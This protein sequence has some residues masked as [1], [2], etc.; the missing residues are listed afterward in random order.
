[1]LVVPV[2]AEEVISA[3]APHLRANATLQRQILEEMCEPEGF[4]INTV[5]T[6]RH[7][8]LRARLTVVEAARRCGFEHATVPLGP[9]GGQ[10]DVILG[11]HLDRLRDPGVWGIVAHWSA[12]SS[13]EARWRQWVARAVHM[14]P[15]S[16]VA[17]ESVLAVFPDA[18][19][20]ARVPEEPPVSWSRCSTAEL[21]GWVHDLAAV[22]D[23]IAAA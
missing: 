1:M 14:D 5:G 16:R 20:L 17:L 22:T 7:R 2:P 9:G 8:P 19:E 10:R 18:F 4:D 12:G 13:R 11:R 3:A 21:T 15:A 6:K 23:A